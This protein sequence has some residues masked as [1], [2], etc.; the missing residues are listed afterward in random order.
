MRLYKVVHVAGL[1]GT[2]AAL[3]AALG[4]TGPI[5]LGL[6]AG[7]TT[8]QLRNLPTTAAASPAAA[9]LTAEQLSDFE[10]R[11]GGALGR[12][13]DRL[14]V[15]AALAPRL[16]VD[17][18]AG[19]NTMAAEGRGIVPASSI[20]VGENLTSRP[21]EQLE[22]VLA[23]EL[24]HL[25]L[26]HLSAMRLTR[27]RE[28]GLLG[29]LGLLYAAGIAGAIKAALFLVHLSVAGGVTTAALLSVLGS[30]GWLAAGFGVLWLAMQFGLGVLRRQELEAD[31][32][33]AKAGGAE[34]LLGHFGVMTGG[35]AGTVQ[36]WWKR[37]LA[38]LSS[39]HPPYEVRI[40]RLR[41]LI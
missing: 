26:G 24:G 41:D 36:P 34:G 39:T 28:A 4:W 11:L 22:G 5:A 32:F 19:R 31:W 13:L 3:M 18:A 17:N 21:D 23:H 33:A 2:F 37:R 30:I 15:D 27:T 35:A 16:L 38:E 29:Q 14:G 12:V 8:W 40:R 6:V 25:S 20:H 7:W 9:A 10:R 1:V